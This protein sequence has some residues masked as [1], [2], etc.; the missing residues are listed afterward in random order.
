MKKLLS[1]PV[2]GFLSLTDEQMR[3]VSRLLR[4]KDTGGDD[5]STLATLPPTF[6]KDKIQCVKAL[7]GSPAEADPSAIETKIR[8][9]LQNLT[10][11]QITW[12]RDL[13][14][15]RWNTDPKNAKNQAYH[16]FAEAHSQ[17][18][19]RSVAYPLVKAIALQKGATTSLKD[20]TTAAYGAYRCQKN[21]PKDAAEQPKSQKRSIRPGMK[22]KTAK[23]RANSKHVPNMK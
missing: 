11:A 8:F 20:L 12:V 7:L 18:I 16:L 6:T 17:C 21:K 1:N 5:E 9:L 2:N 10:D 13:K 22:I 23:G 3:C 15:T 19:R 4:T 14:N